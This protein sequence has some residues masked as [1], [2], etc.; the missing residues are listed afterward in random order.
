MDPTRPPA[1]PNFQTVQRLLVLI[2]L[3]LVTIVVWRM[4]SGRRTPLFNANARPRPVTPRGDLAGDEQA[5]IELFEAV[6]PS[7]VYITT[8]ARRRDAFSFNIFE[9]PQGSGSGIIWDEDGHIVTNHHVLQGAE[10]AIVT[11]FDQSTHRARLV[12]TH[13]DKDLAVLK[14]DVPPGGLLP[15]AV[16]GSSDLAVGQKVFAIGNPFGLDATLTTGI[17]S[18]L[19]REIKSTSGRRIRGVIQTDAAINPGNSGGPLLDSSGRLIGVNAAILSPSGVYAGVGF[20]IPVDTVNDIIPQIIR[21]GRVV[22]PGLGIEAFNDRTARRFGVQGVLVATVLQGSAAARAGIRP[23]RYDSSGRVIPGD[24]IVAIDG[25]A[26][27]VFEDLLEIL[28]TYEVGQTVTVTVQREGRS[29]NLPV[30]LQ[31]IQ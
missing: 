28:E 14:I 1:P 4:S 13:E 3:L 5:T 16:G 27:G 24:V 23:S 21:H 15:I 17:I 6:S 25:K 18:A 29:E 12:G 8:L 2:L 20:A 30:N 7:V 9:I 10:G 31:A 11:L 22:R 26:I 19:G